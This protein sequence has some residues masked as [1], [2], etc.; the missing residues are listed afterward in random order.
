MSLMSRSLTLPHV[1]RRKSSRWVRLACAM[2]VMSMSSIALAYNFKKLEQAIETL[3]PRTAK[4]WQ[5]K[6]NRGD[7]M[8]Q[9]VIGMAYKYG[10]G[11]AQDHSASLSW[12]RKAARQGEA[13]AQFNLARIYESRSDGIYRRTRVLPS[14]DAEAGAWYRRAA[15]Q[16]HTPAQVK[17]AALFAEGAD[18]VARD[19]VQAYMWL[20]AAS[21]AGDLGAAELVVT[22]AAAPTADQK[23]KADEQARKLSNR[24]L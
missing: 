18:G 24:A 10:I 13:D 9:N 20:Q 19:P 14:D 1:R 23:A 15:E 17:L 16:G 12:F 21:L 5:V 11:V 22:Y 8:A 4:D 3:T 6:A 2:V 7:P